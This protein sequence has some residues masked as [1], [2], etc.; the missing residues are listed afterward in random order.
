[1]IKMDTLETIKVLANEHRYQMLQWL[2]N[3]EQ[4]FPPHA[5]QPPGF[6]GG[7]RVGLIVEKSGLAQS[8]VSAYLD[9]L[10]KAGLIESKRAG[11]WTYY[12]YN[13]NFISQFINQL[14]QEI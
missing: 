8:V 13:R 11:R 10:K 14:S 3:P 12:R 4:H 7:V 6:H 1:M 5:C 9:S 2:K